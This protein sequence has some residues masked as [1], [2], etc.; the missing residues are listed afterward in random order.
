MVWRILPKIRSMPAC[1]RQ[2]G[3]QSGSQSVGFLGCSSYS[4]YYTF[5]IFEAVL[6]CFDDQLGKFFYGEVNQLV[7]REFGDQSQG[8][9]S[10]Q[11]G[12]RFF[13][14]EAGEFEV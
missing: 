11:G 7:G 5:W 8:G 6:T 10:K 4:F 1:R 3:G 13:Y 9:C 12:K 14:R 2:G